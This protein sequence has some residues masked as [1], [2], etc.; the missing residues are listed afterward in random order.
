MTREQAKTFVENFEIIK[1]FAEGKDVQ[2][3]ASL[4]QAWQNPPST[5]NNQNLSFTNPPE[6]YRIKPEP[7]WK[8]FTT[9]LGLN[10]RYVY[11]KGSPN[12]AYRITEYA[13][14]RN[15]VGVGPFPNSISL[16]KLFE[17]YFFID[18]TICGI[19]VEE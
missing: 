13:S 9:N 14:V 18:N 5:R 8:P 16:Q 10:H 19:L 17:D 12:T 1:A 7:V 11:K 4:N 3:R 2:Y 6:Y 15:E